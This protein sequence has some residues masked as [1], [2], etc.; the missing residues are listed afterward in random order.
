[1]DKQMIQMFNPSFT[2]IISGQS[3][4]GRGLSA[5]DMIE[6]AGQFAKWKGLDV[7]DLMHEYGYE[8]LLRVLW[9]GLC[10]DNTELKE[11]HL[12]VMVNTQNLKDWVTA[13]QRM[14]GVDEEDL[15]DLGNA[16]TPVV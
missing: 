9:F 3:L 8:S 7:T 1:M 16:I 2:F 4:T 10:L 11:E 15:D 12:K 5:G 14:A 6:L 13:L